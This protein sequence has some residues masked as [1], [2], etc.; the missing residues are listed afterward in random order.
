[1][2]EE[3]LEVIAYGHEFMNRYGVTGD[4]AH[5]ILDMSGCISYHIVNAFSYKKYT[6]TSIVFVAIICFLIFVY[7]MI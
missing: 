7:L 6:T 1:M 2:N 5:L 3:L 4:D